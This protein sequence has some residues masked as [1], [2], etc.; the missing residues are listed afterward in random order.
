MRPV[1]SPY[2]RRRPDLKSERDRKLTTILA[3]TREKV[4]KEGWQA[5]SMRG[6]IRLLNQHNLNYSYY[7]PTKLSL[8]FSLA[9]Q[10]YGLLIRLFKDEIRK[11]HPTPFDTLQSCTQLM[12]FHFTY[13]QN[14]LDI[15]LDREIIEQYNNL[16]QQNLNLEATNYRQ[17]FLQEVYALL[18]QLSDNAIAVGKEANNPYFLLNAWLY[19][20]IGMARLGLYT[21]LKWSEQVIIASLSLLLPN[22]A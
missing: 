15:W 8:G 4:L 9:E 10:E 5:T 2:L 18:Y 3:L 13:S 16:N 11:K 19:H 7:F 12:L 20:F 1:S 17:Q 6:V 21:D 14:L 22:I